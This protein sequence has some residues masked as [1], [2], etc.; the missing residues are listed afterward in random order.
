MWYGYRK[1]SRNRDL[2]GVRITEKNPLSV[3]KKKKAE[4]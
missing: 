2:T 1:D 4:Y 3:M